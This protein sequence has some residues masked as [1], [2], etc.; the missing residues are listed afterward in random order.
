MRTKLP[1]STLLFTTIPSLFL[2]RHLLLPLPSP[3]LLR[4]DDQAIPDPTFPSLPS[5]LL[6]QTLFMP[7]LLTPLH[8]ILYQIVINPALTPSNPTHKP[9]WATL[10]LTLP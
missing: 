6:P 9:I 3:V 1:L 2:A 7:T 8:L 5:F 4:N 10:I